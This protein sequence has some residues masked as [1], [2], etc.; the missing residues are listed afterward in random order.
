MGRNGW[1][2]RTN[3]SSF[4]AKVQNVLFRWTPND[5]RLA[6]F[7]V[8]ANVRLSVPE[9]FADYLRGRFFFVVLRRRSHR[10][11]ATKRIELFEREHDQVNGTA[12][13]VEILDAAGAHERRAVAVECLLVCTES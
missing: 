7:Q 1:S 10:H 5:A 3:G 9:S 11:G 4:S 2:D 8:L 12:L 6:A 13:A